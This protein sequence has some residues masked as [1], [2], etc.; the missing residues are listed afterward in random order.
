MTLVYESPCSAAPPIADVLQRL[1]L[2]MT[3]AKDEEI[4]GQDENAELVHMVSAG[5]VRTTRLTSDGRRQI[6]AFYYPGDLIGPETGSVHRFSAEAVCDATILTL[7][8]GALEAAVGAA[9]LDRM[10]WRAAQR[11]LDRAHDHIQLLGHRS[12]CERVASFLLNLAQRDRSR[13][14]GGRIVLPMSRQDMADYLGLTIET[15]S[16]MLT[17]LQGDEIVQF[18]GAR[19]FGV[20]HWDALTSLAA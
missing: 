9:E 1:G 14:Q 4:F 2:K 11:E 18:Q 7:R 15:V 12:A 13:S 19:T 6:G 5:V 17:Q 8:R 16:R 10:L 20:K 3:Y